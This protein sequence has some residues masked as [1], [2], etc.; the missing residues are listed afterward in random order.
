MSIHVYNTNFH[1]LSIN[2]RAR[3]VQKASL[4][5]LC[6]AAAANMQFNQKLLLSHRP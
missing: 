5:G 3:R 4:L 1:E 6:R 2:L